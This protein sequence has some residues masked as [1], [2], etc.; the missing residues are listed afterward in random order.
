MEQPTNLEL[1]IRLQDDG[2]VDIVIP[3][4]VDMTIGDVVLL[5]TLAQSKATMAYFV[6]RLEVQST[7]E[8]S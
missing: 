1:T 2:N 6:N 8:S 3:E 7:E 4:G 5:L